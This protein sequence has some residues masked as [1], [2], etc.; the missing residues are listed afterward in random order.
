MTDIFGAQEHT[1]QDMRRRSR[2]RDGARGARRR[3]I[4]SFIVMIAILAGL[5]ALLFFV[6][7]PMLSPT[8][9]ATVVVTDYPGPGA[10]AVEVTV[11]DGA[12]GADIGQILYDAG[13]VAT[14]GAFTDAYTA[15]SSATSIQA[16][17]YQLLEEM[18]AAD[19]VAGLL[20]PARRV[21]TQITIPEGWRSDQT[22]QRVADLLGVGLEEVQ[23]AA[24]DYEALGLD[25]APTTDE[26]AID[27]MEGWF[28]PGTYTVAPDAE[29]SDVLAEMVQRTVTALDEAGVAP[30][31]RQEV[32]TVA[33]IAV[34][35]VLSAEDYG[36]VARVIENRLQPDN[37]TG[38]NTLGMDST[39]RYA[40]DRENP[41]E[42]MDPQLHNDSTSAYNTRNVPGLPPTPIGGVDAT[43]I[44]AVINPPEGDWV[45]FVTLDLCTGETVFTESEDEFNQLKLEF[46]AWNE[47]Y[48]ANGSTC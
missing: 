25:G 29:V 43:A 14:V 16:G 5:G 36:R 23:A 17:T 48:E 12:T 47:Q 32:L 39:L 4:L 10:D 18:R 21:D 3:S 42:A 37:S 15:N 2:R 20:D 44:Q 19:A 6:V 46:Q 34:R 45:W 7:R 13:V 33:S 35:E 26:D 40:W 38:A 24:S 27:P 22:Y 31:D 1:P 8:V 30:E 11:P 28:F 41:G 9:E